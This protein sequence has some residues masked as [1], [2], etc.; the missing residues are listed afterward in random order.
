MSICLDKMTRKKVTHVFINQIVNMN[1]LIAIMF[2]EGRL[3]ITTNQ[4]VL[5]HPRLLSA[6]SYVFFFLFRTQRKHM[7]DNKERKSTGEV[8]NISVWMFYSINNVQCRELFIYL[9]FLQKK[10][11]IGKKKNQSYCK[12][13]T[14]I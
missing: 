12:A 3:N 5:C 14:E 6:H 4:V 2:F 9:F 7:F 10:K 13:Q 1:I 11:R 8:S